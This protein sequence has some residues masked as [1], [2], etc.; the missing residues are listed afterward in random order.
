MDSTVIEMDCPAYEWTEDHLHEYPISEV[1]PNTES[2]SLMPE[3]DGTE[4]SVTFFSDSSHGHDKVTGKSVSNIIG[5]IGAAPIEWISKRQ[6]AVCTSTYAA[7]FAALSTCA[8]SAEAMA[9]YLRSFG[10]E[11]DG[12]IDI[13]SDSASALQSIL[14]TAELKKK[15]VMLHYHK[16]REVAAKG[17]VVYRFVEGAYNIADILTKPL[18]REQHWRLLDMIPRE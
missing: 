10:I 4:V 8:E 2:W 7:E 6:G 12:P 18:S 1:S 16:A 15:H 9:L 3:S 14:P 17:L 11:L 13:L 5:F